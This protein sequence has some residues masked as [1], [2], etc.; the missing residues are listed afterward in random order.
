LAA[1]LGGMDR[2]EA[3]AIYDAGRDV[4]V[5]FML[6]LAARV[7]QL[8]DRLRRLEERS[9]QS[10]RNSS[11]PPSQDPPETRQQAKAVERPAVDHDDSRFAHGGAVTPDALIGV[12]A[13]RARR[14][15]AV[16]RPGTWPSASW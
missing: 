11:L 2:A 7:G 14:Y 8:E 16:S 3:E 9:Q 15:V 10:S 1:N 12:T 13:V 5:E 6:E 4:C